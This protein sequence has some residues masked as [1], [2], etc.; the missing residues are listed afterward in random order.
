MRQYRMPIREITLS[1]IAIAVIVWVG[2]GLQ[3]VAAMQ[4]TGT[5]ADSFTGPPPTVVDSDE[6]ATARAVYPAGARAH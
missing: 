4:R 2:T 1:A 3:G 6:V 5:L